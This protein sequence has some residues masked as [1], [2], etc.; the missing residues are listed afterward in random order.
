MFLN[1][2][3]YTDAQENPVE[4][5]RDTL[6]FSVD[7]WGS[8]RAMA[9]VWGIV[10]G[11]DE[12]AMSDLARLFGWDTATTERLNRLHAAFDRLSTDTREEHGDHE[13]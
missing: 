9:W 6:A 8:S 12:D 10:N 2:R 5:L 13:S 4:S 11:W 1:D 7:D 3:P